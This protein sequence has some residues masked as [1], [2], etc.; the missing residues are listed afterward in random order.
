MRA[1]NEAT[2]AQVEAADPANSTW[3]SANAGSG[4]TRVLTE[5]V[6][7]LLLGGVDPQNIL[8]LTFTKAA[9]AEMQNRLFHR[10]GSWAMMEA[11][12]LREELSELGAAQP[13]ELDEARRLF[14]RAIETPG[15]LKIQTIHAFC[16]GVLRRFPLEAGISPRF[17][18]MEDRAAAL[19]RAEILDEL[20]E[21]DPAAVDGIARLYTG[22]D[23]A[24]LTGEITANRAAFL[25]PPNDDTLAAGF[26]AATG[27][28]AAGIVRSHLG[29]DVITL[30][31]EVHRVC[32]GGGKN[33][34]KAADKLAPL[35]GKREMDIPAFHVL[36][37]VF[38]TGGK[39]KAPY[40]AKLTGFPTK[41]VRG[42]CAELMGRLDP[43]MQTVE[44]I[45]PAVIA[46]LAYERT[47]ALYAFATPFCRA[48]E[49]KKLSRGLLDFDDLILKTRALLEDRA[50]AQWV[51]FR[52]D[53]GIDHILVDEA[54]DTSPDQWRV[55]ER[56]TDELAAGRGAGED[57]ERTLFVVGDKKQSI[58]S[59]QGADAE[60]FEAKRELFTDRLA[61]GGGKLHSQPLQFSFRSAAAILQLVDATFQGDLREGL[62]PVVYHRTFKTELPGRV[63]L[64][65]VEPEAEK[66]DTDAPWYKPVDHVSEQHH[67]VKL[68]RR[69]AEQIQTLINRKATIPVEKGGRI[70][71]R[72]IHEGDILILVQRRSTLFAEIIRACKKLGLRIAGADRLRVGA[73]LAV[74]DL[75]ALLRFLALPEDDLSLAAALR[76]PLFGWTEQELFTLAHHRRGLLWSAL[77]DSD[78]HP[79]T[80]KTL[81]DLRAQTDFLRPYDLLSRILIRHGGRQKLLDRL[82]AE[83]EDGIDALLAQALA[84][85][86]STVPSLTGFLSWM[87]TEDVEVKR[88]MDE[89]GE[90]IRV[91]TIH[92]AK[93][94]EAP[95]V[96]LPE[97]GVRQTQSDTR[98]AIWP[99]EDV[100]AWRPSTDRL[101]AA[102]QDA[103]AKLVEAEERERRRLLYVALTRAEKWLIVC[104]AGK[105]GKEVGDSWYGMVEAGLERLGALPHP[106]PGGD[107]LRYETGDW[108]APDLA[109]PE[110]DAAE[111][112][113][114]PNFA[115]VALPPAALQT[116]SPSDLGGAKVL[117][118]DP[119]GGDREAALE[120]GNQVHL[121][122]EH[123]PGTL[124]LE[125]ANVALSLFPDLPAPERQSL[126]TDA[127]AVLSAP[128]LAEL[129]EKGLAEVP[130]TATLAELNGA[131]LHGTIDLLIPGEPLR[132][133]DFKTNRLVPKTP[134][135]VPEGLLRQMGAYAA[136]LGQIYPGRAIETAILWTSTAE[137]MPLPHSLVIA[138]LLRAGA[139]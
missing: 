75:A 93:G 9:A 57:R 135:E 86:R 46:Q 121:L 55:I 131:R 73:E 29:A 51:L 24:D 115:P 64:W 37:D 13:E 78:D 127:E 54:Q 10:L 85:E 23:I 58:Y 109:P 31:G 17:T 44:D 107:G 100:V 59:F 48:F 83:A 94:L 34:T 60:M 30:L 104:G 74:R 67:D 139:P 41:A 36:C 26:G 118:G 68:A 28:T 130:V 4:K 80:L 14:A 56:L 62:D 133:I 128:G 91:M 72:P 129:F 32:L 81:R 76:S 136:A 103:R 110:P 15:G 52:L 53:G 113:A 111:P 106:Q 125:R 82:G 1:W 117:P 77:R 79:E 90:R 27:L 89:Q 49:T 3:L 137:L 40:S 12:K 7:R 88:Q 16:A 99:L 70:L 38:L 95:V 71:R 92:G 69:V 35:L 122:L 120:R 124:P 11:G 39:A 84:Y 138:A 108:S 5:R 63:D 87:E 98:S 42:S 116:L 119:A 2:R 123:L 22:A 105:I 47:R 97:T 102:L 112:V 134:E 101:P 21:A 50:L 19:L 66:T 18:E 45:R 96:I 132:V 114:P 20:A 33:D 126:L 65:P 43:V 25:D 61:T 6:A 8:C